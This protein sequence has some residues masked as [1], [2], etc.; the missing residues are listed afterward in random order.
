MNALR[1]ALPALTMLIGVAL[2]LAI[3][4]MR[5]EHRKASTDKP[6]TSPI[7]AVAPSPL[8]E[9]G[10][11]A[12]DGEGGR[13]TIPA[14]DSVVQ[15]CIDDDQARFD[16]EKRTW[17]V[18]QETTSYHGLVFFTIAN[19]SDHSVR[20]I[21]VR[22]ESDDPSAFEIYDDQWKGLLSPEGAMLRDEVRPMEYT[23]TDCRSIFLP[24]PEGTTMDRVVQL[25]G[26]LQYNGQ[27]TTLNTIKVYLDSR[28]GR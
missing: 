12:A 28:F 21:R 2:G 27:W 4:D 5:H 3:H 11:P 25:T 17:S 24:V 22:L 19:L 6:I 9:S 1:S 8:L 10:Q 23:G 14:T 18:S 26:Y 20:G 13:V 16:L 7:G 15:A